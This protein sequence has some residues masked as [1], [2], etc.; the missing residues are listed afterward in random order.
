MQAQGQGQTR[1]Q[2]I[3]WW[4][5]IVITGLLTL[6]GVVW[7]FVGPGMSA[8]YAAQI[9]NMPPDAFTGLYPQLV[10][11]LGDNAQQTGVLYAAFG[12]MGWIAAVEGV[13][14]GTRWAWMVTWVAVAAPIVAGLSYLGDGLSFDNVG[15]IAIGLV[16]LVGQLLSTRTGRDV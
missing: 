3:G 16:A 7:Y 15:Q 11:H 4:I 10:H 13:R 1:L 6:N 9:T 14:R 8:S 5:L 12:L 2:K